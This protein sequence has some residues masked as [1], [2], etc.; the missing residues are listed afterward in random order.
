VPVL[1]CAS[2]SL[3]A[4][5]GDK[6]QAFHVADIQYRADAHF[7]GEI[8]QSCDVA[9]IVTHAVQS[10]KS[11]TR[12]TTELVLRIDRVA[13]LR[14]QPPPGPSAAGTELGVSIL[15]VGPR[16]IDQ[17][18]LCRMNTLMGTSAASHCARVV[19]CSRT[20][21]EQISTWLAGS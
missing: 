2:L 13:K 18:F 16:Q 4:S 9:K 20:I 17:P 6:P 12:D 15:A 10:E 11:T 3:R 1:L 8:L 14:G 7:D 19:K 5:A 21:A